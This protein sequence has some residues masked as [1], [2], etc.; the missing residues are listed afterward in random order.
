MNMLSAGVSGTRGTCIENINFN[1]LCDKSRRNCRKHHVGI[2]TLNNTGVFDAGCM[3]MDISCKIIM[4]NIT[5]TM[6]Q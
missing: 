1:Y 5:W 2:F 6:I 3:A 4:P